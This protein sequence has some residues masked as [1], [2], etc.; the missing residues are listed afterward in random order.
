MIL[1]LFFSLFAVD[2]VYEK[3]KARWTADMAFSSIFPIK[4]SNRLIAQNLK[5]NFPMEAAWYTLFAIEK[6]S[7]LAMQYL[8]LANNELASKDHD[9]ISQILSDKKLRNKQIGLL[10]KYFQANDTDE[11]L[12]TAQNLFE[13]TAE[14]V[15]DSGEDDSQ[16]SKQDKGRISRAEKRAKTDSAPIAPWLAEVIAREERYKNAYQEPKKNEQIPQMF[17]IILS[18]GRRD[19]LIGQATFNPLEDSYVKTE[20]PKGLS[21]YGGS[22]YECY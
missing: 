14:S 15:S 18:V 9:S 10:L 22:A 20:T 2:Q 1:T 5:L 16:G 8:K 17:L 19:A 7:K 6:G 21:L 3:A 12:K 4:E 13:T 11:I